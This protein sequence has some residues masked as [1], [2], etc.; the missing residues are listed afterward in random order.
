[1]V[2]GGSYSQSIIGEVQGWINAGW[3]V[4]THSVSHEYWDP[5][6]ADA[7]TIEPGSVALR[8][9][10][11]PCVLENLQYTGAMASSVRLTISHSATVCGA[12]EYWRA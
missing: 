11:L 5:P 6:A 4:N 10:S 2:T 12:G 9:N 3:D 7:A 8:W 1:M